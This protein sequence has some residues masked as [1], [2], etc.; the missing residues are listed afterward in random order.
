V[1]ARAPW[2]PRRPSRNARQAS[3]RA[4]G[5]DS[6]RAGA[7]RLG[8]CLRLAECGARLTPRQLAVC[9]CRAAPGGWCGRRSWPSR[10]ASCPPS[11]CRQLDRPPLGGANVKAIA[12]SS[13][14]NGGDGRR[15]RSV[16]RKPGARPATGRSS[17]EKPPRVCQ[18][19]AP[20]AVGFGRTSTRCDDAFHAG[21][22][23]P[24]PH[25]LNATCRSS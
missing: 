18:W 25:M 15:R 9:V 5:R 8:G 21:S 3:L 17:Q 24:T 1:A 20:R 19:V 4:I 2:R 10:N 11:V 23:Q 16:R 22:A 14:T 6:V 13:A 12:P 7:Y